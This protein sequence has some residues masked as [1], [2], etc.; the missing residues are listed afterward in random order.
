MQIT[1]VGA[2]NMARGIATRALAG[3]H[4]VTVTAKDPGKAVRLVD[5]LRGQATGEGRIAAAD[6]TAVD[7]ADIVVLAVPFDAAKELATAYGAQLS[8]KVLIDISNPVDASLDALVVASGTS[9]AEEI[10]EAAAPGTRVVKAFNTTFA[11]TLVAGQVSGTPLDVFIAGDDE[12]ARRQVAA[13]VTSCGLSP[14]DV[15]ALKHARELEGFQ[16]LHMA[17]QTREGGH[18]WASTVKIVTP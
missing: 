6:A 14:V 16:L 2:G 4:T 3:G 8:G 13:L 1:I 7:T 5:E 15:G 17:M 18:S 10:A 11:T 12:A 9:A